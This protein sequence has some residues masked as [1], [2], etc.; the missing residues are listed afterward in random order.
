MA[1]GYR[2]SAAEDRSVL[3]AGL[4]GRIFGID[5]RSGERLWEHAIVGEGGLFGASVAAGEVEILVEGD[6]IFAKASGPTLALF[7][8]PS[9]RLLGQLQV[10]GS[11]HGRSTML[12]E[13]GLLFVA[14]GGEITCVRADDGAVLWHD[15]MSGK[16]IG[17]VALAFPGKVRQ[18]DDAGSR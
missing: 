4:K 17:S 12:L 6:R 1:E 5:A 13:N 8:Y 18:A 14:S 11:Y 9:G 15:P 7:E 2:T 10:P 3:V 16:G